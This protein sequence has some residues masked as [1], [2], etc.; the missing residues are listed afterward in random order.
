[1]CTML[2]YED[3]STREAAP[4]VAEPSASTLPLTSIPVSPRNFANDVGFVCSFTVATPVSDR[5]VTPFT[6]SLPPEVTS[7][8]AVPP[9]FL[10]ALTDP[11]S[12]TLPSVDLTTTLPVELTAPD[13]L[14]PP[15]L[16]RVT[17]CPVTAAT[18]TDS[19]SLLTTIS[20]P[21]LDKLPISIEPLAC[22]VISAPFA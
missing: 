8:D 16:C 15:L 4:L 18:L 3:I 2:P 22:S 9:S 13:V 17:S 10:I 20:P 14:N 7:T 21:L 1:D 11:F 6:A 19:L 12:A 5:A